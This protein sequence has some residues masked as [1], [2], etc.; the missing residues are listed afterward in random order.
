MIIG[1]QWTPGALAL[2]ANRQ[3]GKTDA[4]DDAGSPLTAVPLLDKGPLPAAVAKAMIAASSRAAE[5]SARANVLGFK[6]Q[7]IGQTHKAP[8][9]DFQS[10]LVAYLK[11]TKLMAWARD[12]KN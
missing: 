2:A 7:Q 8:A 12:P 5:M 3:Q 11:T 1:L 10:N 4:A 9:E 6:A